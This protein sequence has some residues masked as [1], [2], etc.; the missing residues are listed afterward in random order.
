MA[1]SFNKKLSW[2]MGL[3]ANDPPMCSRQRSR[4]KPLMVFNSLRLLADAR[5]RINMASIHASRATFRQRVL[6]TGNPVAR[7]SDLN[8]SVGKIPSTD[9]L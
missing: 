6:T 3:W 2:Q 5:S 9:M 8:D 4:A 1:L 7:I